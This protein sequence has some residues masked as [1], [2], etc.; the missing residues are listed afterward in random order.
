MSVKDVVISLVDSE[1]IGTSI[2]FWAFPRCNFILIWTF[3]DQKS[4]CILVG[5]S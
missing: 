5:K 1:K 4:M 2:Y 3:G